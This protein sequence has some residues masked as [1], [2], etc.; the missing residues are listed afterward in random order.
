MATQINGVVDIQN[1]SIPDVKV[2]SLAWSKITGRPTSLAGYG[3]VGVSTA[4]ITGILN[5]TQGG[6]GLS[7]FAIGDLIYASG[8][9]ALSKLPAVAAGSVLVSGGVGAAP[10][11]SATPTLSEAICSIDAAGSEF[12][13]ARISD[14]GAVGHFNFA[15]GNAVNAGDANRRDHALTI[16]YN[17]KPSGGRL[18][19]AE[20]C[21]EW[22]IEDYYKPSSTAFLES[23]WHYYD[24]LGNGLRPIAFQVNRSN[25]GYLTDS[26][27]ALKGTSLSYL[28]ANDTQ[29]AQFTGSAFTLFASVPIIIDVNNASALK[30]K[31]AAGNGTIDLIHLGTGND[32]IVGGSGQR[33]VVAVTALQVGSTVGAKLTDFAG[34]GLSLLRSDDTGAYLVLKEQSTP[35]AA[36]AD[37]AKLYVKDNGSGKTQLCVL[38]SSGAEQVLVTQP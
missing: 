5:P 31:N 35:G 16:G 18:N 14:N 27:L 1:A 2:I 38:F 9:T 36:S 25:G 32:V 8:P 29:Y 37:T 19:T 20:P 24:A 6:T 13:S 28:G 21:F 33:N 4:D 30:Q 3:I 26:T 7:S 34:Q 10:A 23:H 17:T 12:L 22:R 15:V 11:W